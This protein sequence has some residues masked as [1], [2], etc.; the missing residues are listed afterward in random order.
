MEVH[1]LHSSNIPPL[2]LLNRHYCNYI[3]PYAN[4]IT[5]DC[6]PR[7]QKSQRLIKFGPVLKIVFHLTQFQHT[8]HKL[9]P[10]THQRPP[11]SYYRNSINLLQIKRLTL[12]SKESSTN[13]L[14]LIQR[15]KE[16]FFGAQSAS[17]DAEGVLAAGAAT[18]LAKA[19]VSVASPWT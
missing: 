17:L 10:H 3:K 19:R 5:K 1:S 13:A 4:L 18:G 15:L 9:H 8:K 2:M 6:D 12:D 11:S 7:D 16:E 14:E